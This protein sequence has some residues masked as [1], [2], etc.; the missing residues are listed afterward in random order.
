M[1]TKWPWSWISFVSIEFLAF[2]VW[3]ITCFESPVIFDTSAQTNLLK[4]ILS[5][6]SRGNI[7]INHTSTG[8]RYKFWSRNE[9]VGVYAGCIKWRCKNYS[10]KMCHEMAYARNSNFSASQLKFFLHIPS[11]GKSLLYQDL[12]SFINFLALYRISAYISFKL[13]I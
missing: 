1:N 10:E 3:W 9:L 4:W 2:T 12:M 6:P 8:M 7:Q 5:W 13:S 11:H